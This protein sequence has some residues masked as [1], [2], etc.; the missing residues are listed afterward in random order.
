MYG[1]K[2]K[3]EFRFLMRKASYFFNKIAELYN[4]TGVDVYT[5]GVSNSV[6]IWCKKL[7]ETGSIELANLAVSEYYNRLLQE[8][9]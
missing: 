8:G 9:I 1:C 7:N 6:S 4:T 2:N 5:N 3:D